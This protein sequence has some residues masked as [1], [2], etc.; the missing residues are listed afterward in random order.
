MP[1][2]TNAGISTRNQPTSVSTFA[3]GTRTRY[4]PRTAAIAPLA[5]TFGMLACSAPAKSSV[6]HVCRAVAAIPPAMYQKKKRTD[7]SASS[8]LFPKI[9]RKSMFP[10]RCSRPPC[11][12]IEA[13]APRYQ[14]R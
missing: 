1:R 10:A 3:P 2:K 14:G 8:T 6:T 11:M 12:N 9:Q 4:A 7:P 13:R 5:P